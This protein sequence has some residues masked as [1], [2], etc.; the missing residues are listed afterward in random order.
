MR[1]KTTGA[2][3][4][5]ACTRAGSPRKSGIPRSGVFE[6]GGRYTLELPYRDD[7][8]LL[9]EILKHRAGVEVLGPP[10][11]R[12]KVRRASEGR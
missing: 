4:G 3:S 11:L 12:Q 10:E 6:P 7:R 8:D 9:L 5:R 1:M 2:S